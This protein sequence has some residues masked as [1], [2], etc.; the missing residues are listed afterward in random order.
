MET[1]RVLP[2]GNQIL[3]GAAIRFIPM[4]YE[5]DNFSPDFSLGYGSQDIDWRHGRMILKIRGQP[6]SFFR[7]HGRNSHIFRAADRPSRPGTFSL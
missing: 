4:G 1:G 6:N 5:A 7:R 2:N 3:L